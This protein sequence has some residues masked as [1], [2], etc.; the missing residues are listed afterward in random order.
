[1]TIAYDAAAKTATHFVSGLSVEFSR[2]G[3]YTK[4]RDAY[5][6]LSYA[7][8]TYPFEASYDSGTEKIV[9]SEPNISALDLSQRL[10]DLN[11]MN[12]VV[13][14][15]GA[16]MDLIM[17]TGL[18]ELPQTFVKTWHRAIASD[19]TYGTRILSVSYQPTKRTGRWP[20]NK[21]AQLDFTFPHPAT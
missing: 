14:S 6:V 8:K 11:E 17:T 13:R 2:Y 3:P 12:F 5:F 15:L 21:L 1:M 4:E 16:E 20:F 19:A 7:G 9:K 18:E 10:Y